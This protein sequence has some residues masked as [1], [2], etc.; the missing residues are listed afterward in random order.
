MS[1][2]YWTVP[3]QTATITGG[4]NP[5]KA[6]QQVTLTC[7][8]SLSNPKAVITWYSR[9]KIVSANS[10]TVYTPGSN[11]GFT[12]RSS[13]TVTMS[14]QENNAM[15]ICNAV[16]DNRAPVAT[17]NVTL[18]VLC[19]YQPS[20]RFFSAFV[21]QCACSFLF[22]SQFWAKEHLLRMPVFPRFPIFMFKKG[23]QRNKHCF[24]VINDFQLIFWYCLS[25][26]NLN[27]IWMINLWDWLHWYEIQYWNQLN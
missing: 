5:V 27:P 25:E 21:C 3:P 8:S 6:G 2:L 20:F 7:E 16:S 1:A 13:V 14:E 10:D 15:Y 19:E 4:G 22:F 9:G 12:S 24:R 26:V 11:G 23:L 18:S 17:A